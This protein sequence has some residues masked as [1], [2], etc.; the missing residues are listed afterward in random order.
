MGKTNNNQPNEFNNNGTVD[1]SMLDQN[2]KNYE[3]SDDP[4]DRLINQAN[5][6]EQQ[7]QINNNNNMDNNNMNNMN[8]QQNNMDNMD[9]MNNMNNNM[10]N[11][12]NNMN[13]QQ[14]NMNNNGFNEESAFEEKPKSKKLIIPIIIIAVI[15]IAIV[16]VLLI[17]KNG[18]VE[19]INIDIP[20][21][22]YTGETRDFIV[23]PEGKGN[24]KKV[25][26]TYVTE[27]PNLLTLDNATT[28]GIFNTN[29][30]TVNN[31]GKT[32]LV[33]TSTLGKKTKT[34]KKELTLCNKLDDSAF[35][36]NLIT[37]KE[38]ERYLLKL[39]VGN[40]N[41]CYANI[42]Y[43][44]DNENIATINEYNIIKGLKKGTTNIT[45]SK[46]DYTK[47]IKIVVK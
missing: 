6:N 45:I 4:N 7:N 32:N 43:H 28:T 16:V 35:P 27:N 34:I 15:I 2:Q 37:I 21:V 14:N 5:L 1:S 38:N 12:M 46:N 24:L 47:T 31:T 42:D 29:K 9:N 8:Y 13:Y 39:N 25:K 40:D 18:T 41:K 19:N 11:N 10:D 17:N 23:T 20:D 30:I 22:L 26:F 36:T 33:I 3:I 44:I